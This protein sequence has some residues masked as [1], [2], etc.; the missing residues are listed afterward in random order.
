MGHRILKQLISFPGS[1]P[2][3]DRPDMTAPGMNNYYVVVKKPMW[4]KAVLKR[5]NEDKYPS[6]TELIA[7]I[8]LVLENCYLY[9]GTGDP[10][11]K[12]A[13]RVEE[14][15]ETFVAA[16]PSHV[17]DL[18]SLKATHG[19]DLSDNLTE[20][21]KTDETTQQ[22]GAQPSCQSLKKSVFVSR[23]LQRVLNSAETNS[24]GSENSVV[25]SVG[26]EVE[27]WEK[28][29][30]YNGNVED[31]IASMWELPLIGQFLYL[32]LSLHSDGQISQYE[33]ERM[34]LIPQASTVLA[35]VMTSMLVTPFSRA[36][37]E[38]GPPMPY[39]FWTNKLK[40]KL[41]LW[42][43][44][45]RGTGD[46]T[47][48]VFELIGIEPEFWLVMGENNPL[49]EMQ[50]HELKFIQR[51]WILKSL[52]D[53]LLHNHKSFQETFNNIESDD[54][55]ESYLGRDRQGFAYHYFPEFYEVRIYKRARVPDKRWKDFNHGVEE[56]LFS[57]A[58]DVDYS[59]ENEAHDD[60][61]R[62]KLPRSL[63]PSPKSFKMVAKCVEDV[64]CLIDEVSNQQNSRVSAQ[65]SSPLKRNLSAI[66][67]QLEPNESKIENSTAVL[68]KKMHKE[69]LEFTNRP[70]DYVDPG[71]SYWSRKEL[72]E[73]KAKEDSADSVD[74]VDNLLTVERRE[75]RSTRENQKYVFDELD[76]HLGPEE[77]GEDYEP[78]EGE[79]SEDEWVA[80][81]SKKRK[82]QQNVSQR[83]IKKLQTLTQKLQDKSDDNC[84]NAN[85]RTVETN[86]I[87]VRKFPTEHSDLSFGPS[88][89]TNSSSTNS[90]HVRKFPTDNLSFAPSTT[91]SRDQVNFDQV[92]IK[93]EPQ[94]NSSSNNVQLPYRPLPPLPP[95]IP[96]THYVKQEALKKEATDEC[97][98]FKVKSEMG[99]SKQHTAIT[100]KTTSQ[101]DEVINLLSDDEDDANDVSV[102]EDVKPVIK[103][104]EYYVANNP[105]TSSQTTVPQQQQP[106]IMQTQFQP[107]LSPQPG[108]GFHQRNNLVQ[109]PAQ[110]AP[111]PF[112]NNNPS[113][114]PHLG[115]P[116][117]SIN[118]PPFATVKQEPGT[119][120]PSQQQPVSAP[121]FNGLS[122]QQ[123]SPRI[124]SPQMLRGSPSP[125]GGRMMASSPRMMTSP[126]L[127]ATSPRMMSQQNRSPMPQ[128]GRMPMPPNMGRGSP[129]NMRQRSPQTV[130]FPQRGN[131]SSPQMSSSQFGSSPQRNMQA[132]RNLNFNSPSRP[133]NSNPTPAPSRNSLPTNSSDRPKERLHIIN[134]GGVVG[135]NT[136]T[137]EGKLVVAM[138]DDGTYGYFAVL[139][140]GGKL[141][142]SQKQISELR[143]KCNGSL[144]DMMASPMVITD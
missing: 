52:C 105:G 18:C 74:N 62:Y 13:L 106:G 88:S 95:T 11:T 99:L 37:L 125:R 133:Q 23:L 21:N 131:M 61:L 12:K 79:D 54:L 139:S 30:L 83:K 129:Q 114:M 85:S 56:M 92:K 3:L 58:A 40:K 14:Q 43:R 143:S 132:R 29:V 109:P 123:Q 15:L 111:M 122:P 116:S 80:T 8:R 10:L 134:S 76:K 16:L 51:V 102:V 93:E 81:P 120:M 48:K 136:K 98:A 9:W 42:Y 6:I 33:V 104:I 31:E 59:E 108:M 100:L 20:E 75:R 115:T 87:Q 71:A 66:L 82:K 90:I 34:L 2:F 137:V 24:I 47:V 135:K 60:R 94:E 28:S 46:L 118:A 25:E 27:E 57:T 36:R 117:T 26:P 70:V 4:L 38:E 35:R 112:P 84:E 124:R 91:A 119:V 63:L 32:S 69:W 138:N 67:A 45:Y 78:L 107:M 19:E 22:D 142:V 39:E 49:E 55:R 41:A 72:R 121:M 68:R 127:M 110:M 5:Y 77:D 65:D 126:R 144:P 96:L 101:S 128:R 140:D 141:T 53:Y 7:D 1:T 89:S 50:F 97:N 73:E 130:T 113:L 103:T 64:R 86:S 44:T 17:R